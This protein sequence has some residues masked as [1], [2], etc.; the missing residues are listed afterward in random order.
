[1]ILGRTPAGL[2]KIKK[3]DPL[4]LRA[5]NCACCETCPCSP[6]PGRFRI[7]SAE[8]QTPYNIPFSFPLTITYRSDY[9]EYDPCGYF[10]AIAAEIGEF[11]IYWDCVDKEDMEW[12]G[13][14]EPG[15]YICAGILGGSYLLSGSAEGPFELGLI[16]SAG[17]TLA[18]SV[19]VE[20]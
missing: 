15:P 14:A 3:D 6:P 17:C 20:P 4:G 2:I 7:E 13:W 18:I 1:M 5:V 10:Y 11:Y 12:V 19:S 9:D 8:M 16:S